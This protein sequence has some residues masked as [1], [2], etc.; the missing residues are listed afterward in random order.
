MNWWQ[1]HAD[2]GV[3]VAPSLLAADF[4][5][6]KQEIV[7]V[8]SAGADLLHLDVMDGHFVPN[9][10]FGPFIVAAVK[11]CSQLFLDAHL[12]ISRPDRY[13]E[14]FARSGVDAV[15]IHVE[16][17]APIA[18][19]LDAVRMLGLKIGLSLNPGSD[20]ELVRSYLGELDL[21]LVMAVQPGFGGQ[22]FQPSALEK[23]SELRDIRHKYGYH[24]AISVDGGVDDQTAES[25]RQAGSDILVSGSYLFRSQDREQAIRRLRGL[26]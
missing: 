25:C 9:L 12:M 19:T 14:D 4:T 16:A 13:L 23:I 15:T 18:P 2:S 22:T 21:L 24:Y 7:S 6:L 11:R 17:E 20:L 1:R 5:E 26:P 3:A 8:E 10:T